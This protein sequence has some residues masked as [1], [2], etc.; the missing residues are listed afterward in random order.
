M[1]SG[2]GLLSDLSEYIKVYLHDELTAHCEF[3][4]K[5]KHEDVGC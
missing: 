4:I 1:L 5:N 2:K 3:L